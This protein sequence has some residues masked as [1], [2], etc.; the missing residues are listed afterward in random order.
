MYEPR[1]TRGKDLKFN[2]YAAHCGRGRMPFQKTINN[3]EVPTVALHLY[4]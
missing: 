3:V 2:V 1:A 4:I